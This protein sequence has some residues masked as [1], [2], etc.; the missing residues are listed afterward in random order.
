MKPE[1]KEKLD[2]LIAG[3]HPIFIFAGTVVFPIEAEDFLTEKDLNEV[4]ACIRA[5]RL[6]KNGVI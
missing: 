2:N 3:G 4:R 5:E 6:E 1:T